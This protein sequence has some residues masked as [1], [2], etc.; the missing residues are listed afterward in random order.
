[1][2]VR[3]RFFSVLLLGVM[4]ALSPLAPV[5][6]ADRPVAL[7]ATLILASNEPAAQDSRLD[8]VEY[9]LRRVFGFEYY[10]HYG[11][12]T[13]AVAVPGSTSLTLGHGN[14]LQIHISGAK[15]N[16]LRA[17]VQ[18]FRGNDLVL[19]TTVVVDRRTPVVLGG[20]SHENGTLIVT[21]QAE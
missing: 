9:K 7:K 4:L 5:A 14:R 8:N 18:W 1:M 2:P 11:E 10:R 20:V 16:R 15:D 19:N 21:L 13:A 12:S 6:A 17:Q 3:D